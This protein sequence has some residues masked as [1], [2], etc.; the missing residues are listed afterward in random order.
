MKL[1]AMLKY[2]LCIIG[3]GPAGIMAAIASGERNKKVVLIEKNEDIGKK[4]LLTGGGRCNLTSKGLTKKEFVSKFGKQGDFLLSS[5]SLFGPEELIDFFEKRGFSLKVEEGKVYPKS[6]NSKDVLNFF[7]SE[8]K[9]NKVTVITNKEVSDFLFK[10]KKIEKVLLTDN[11]EIFADNFLIATGGKSYP[12]NISSFN[13]YAFSKKMGHKVSVLSP[14]LTPIEIREK[15]ISVLKGVTLKDVGVKLNN[16]KEIRGDVLCTHFGL[17]GP[18]ILNL[19]QKVKSKDKIFLDLFPKKRSEDLE[20]ELLE[21]FDEN[22]KK[23]INNVLIG[24]LPLKLAPVIIN[25]S[26]IDKNEICRNI[27]KEQRKKLVKNIKNIEF[28]VVGLL[29]FEK[30]M[31]TKGG[32]LLKEID[33]KTLKSKLV[34]NLYFAGEIID[35][36]GESG[37]FNLQM[38]FTTGYAVAQSI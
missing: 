8:L 37:G 25:F 30:A 4:L 23:T 5:M 32:I 27:N 19:S 36:N 29:G 3:G 24:R 13:G 28:N 18:L 16:E 38:C 10:N 9:K 14:A 33:A 17:S 15:W 21:L 2:D 22:I 1:K 11:E 20:K 6:E 35:L 7:K 31:V 34:A 12:N 26:G